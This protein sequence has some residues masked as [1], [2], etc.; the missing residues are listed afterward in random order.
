LRKGEVMWD[1]DGLAAQ[2]W[3]SFPYRKGP[4]FKSAQK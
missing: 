4:Y 2:D 1:R 3:Q